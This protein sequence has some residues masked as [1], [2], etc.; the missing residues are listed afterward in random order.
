[1]RLVFC[2]T[3]EFAVPTLQALVDAG[4]HISLVVTQPDRASGRGL[5]SAQP[6][7]KLTAVSLGLPITQPEKIKKNPEFRAQLEAI[8]PDAI[9]VVA[10]GR[11]IP[12]WMLDLPKYGNVNLHGSLLPKYRGAAPIQWAIANGETESGVTTMLLNEGLDTA[13]MLLL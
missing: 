4:H 8:A 11:M 9:V 5:E 12:K 13:A 6:A 2:G 7:V 10:F 3:P 1:M